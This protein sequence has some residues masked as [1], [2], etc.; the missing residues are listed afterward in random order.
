MVISGVYEEDMESFADV[1][2]N[3][4][5]FNL[6]LTNC[7]SL[8]SASQRSYGSLLLLQYKTYLLKMFSPFSGTRTGSCFYRGSLRVIFISDFFAVNVLGDCSDAL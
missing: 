3:S 7:N 2:T 6:K 1:A 5:H 4:G 8:G